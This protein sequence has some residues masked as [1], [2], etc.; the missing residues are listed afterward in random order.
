MKKKAHTPRLKAQ[1]R[2]AIEY[3]G[4]QHALAAQVGVSQQYISML[5]NNGKRVT[6]EVAVALERAT[7]GT[8]L[9]RELRPDLFGDSNA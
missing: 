7:D 6:G 4:T 9:R 1:L 5:L 3:C 2:R 8:V